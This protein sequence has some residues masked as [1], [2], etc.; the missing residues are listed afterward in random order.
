[1]KKVFFLSFVLF[2]MLTASCGKTHEEVI[3]TYDDGT[4]KVVYVMQGKGDKQQKVGEKMYYEDGKLRYEKHFTGG[5]N[6]GKWCYYYG[7]GRLFAEGDFSQRHDVGANWKFHNSDGGAMVEGK[8]D[9]I[10]VSVFNTDMFPIAMG[11][12]R[13]DSI[14]VKEIYEDISLRSTG[15][16]V[17]GK[18]IG[19]WIFYF[20]TGV[21][22]AEAIYAD[23]VENGMHCAYRENG[24][25]YYRGLYINGKRA[26]VWEF[27]DQDGIL[28]GKQNFDTPIE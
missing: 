21:K 5:V 23:G 4:P 16:L 20:P 26:G 8:V 2:A 19:H 22:Q 25:P 9:S 18:R 3:S 14:T 24:V 15:V 7:N 11:F 12:F 10:V 27:Y 6:D 13:G 17:N 1:M 28:S